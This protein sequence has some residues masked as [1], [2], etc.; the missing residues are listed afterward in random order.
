MLSNLIGSEHFVSHRVI[1]F[2]DLEILNFLLGQGIHFWELPDTC[3]GLDIEPLSH[4]QVVD[5]VLWVIHDTEKQLELIRLDYI[6]EVKSKIGGGS[7][8]GSNF[9]DSSEVD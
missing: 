9:E 8:Q 5:I 6:R 7:N 3:I 1:H 2:F 4:R